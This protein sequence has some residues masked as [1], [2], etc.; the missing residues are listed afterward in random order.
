MSGKRARYL[1]LV[2]QGLISG[3][4]FLLYLYAARALPKAA[5]GEL[6]LA[7]GLILVVQGFQRAF[8][9]IPM[10]T[11]G[12]AA[13]A[14][15]AGLAAWKRLQLLVTLVLFAVLLLAGLVSGLA[16]A[17]WVRNTIVY[18][19]L[20]LLPQFYMEFS[21]RILVMSSDM[22][23]LVGM[24]SVY[25]L[26]LASALG[27]A[28]LLDSADQ[29][30]IFVIALVLAATSAVLFAR[31]GLFM[32]DSS[33]TEEALSWRSVWKFGAWAAGA[34]LAYTG[35]NFL[36]QWLLAFISGPG[37]AGVFAAA[38]NLVQPV[39]TLV[40]AVDTVDKPR[41]GRA[42]CADGMQGL[43]RITRKSWW[44]MFGMAMPFLILVFFFAGDLLALL[45][46][47]KYSDGV[48]AVRLWCLVV[49]L[50]ICVQPL[51]TGLY[52]VRRPDWL[53]M[54]RLLSAVLTLAAT[55]WLIMHWSLHGALVALCVGWGLAGGTAFL[56]LRRQSR[57]ET[58]HG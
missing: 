25:V 27:T 56:Q 24:A 21:R 18:A 52:V 55:P 47:E 2:E 37:A 17:D 26:V 40:Q 28:W 33:A 50:M 43:W 20:L 7:M 38:R 57:L 36:V 9:I 23:R 45:Y 8:V 1:A 35:Y 19:I 30:F 16:F 14:F 12:V 49:L 6:S 34:S 44:W 3:G 13:D 29:V 41:A 54:G 46:G 5:W 48:G 11:S 42:Y 51:E 10:V 22:T 58:L 31:V 4:N 53:F 39:N 15:A 32:L